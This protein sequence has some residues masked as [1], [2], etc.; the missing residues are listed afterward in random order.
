LL[1]KEGESVLDEFIYTLI[2]SAL[3]VLL[4]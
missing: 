4:D 3:D 1:M 2:A